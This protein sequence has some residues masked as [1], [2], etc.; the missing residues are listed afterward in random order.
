[1]RFFKCSELRDTPIYF[2]LNFNRVKYSQQT[3]KNCFLGFSYKKLP[4]SSPY[5]DLMVLEINRLTKLFITLSVG[6]HKN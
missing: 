2:L 1:M 4:A 5:A 3:Y 6:S